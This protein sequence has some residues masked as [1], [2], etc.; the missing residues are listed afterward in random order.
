MHVQP[1]RPTWNIKITQ[2]SKTTKKKKE[3]VFL[4]DMEL[5]SSLRGMLSFLVE[6]SEKCSWGKKKKRKN[7]L[8]RNG[9]C[10]ISC[11]TN[12]STHALR[13]NT[14]TH[15]HTHKYTH[16]YTLFLRA[17]PASFSMHR[18]RRTCSSGSKAVGPPLRSRARYSL[19]SWG[20]AFF[21]FWSSRTLDSVVFF[22]SDGLS[23]AV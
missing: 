22:Q 10:F 13:W 12:A 3:T 5:V 4:T 18:S 11:L 23:H 21:F 9:E 14:H 1:P 8:T 15:I 16:T 6:H 17:V 19:C 7:T 2:K 20:S